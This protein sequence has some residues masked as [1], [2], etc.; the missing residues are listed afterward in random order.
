MTPAYEE[1]ANPFAVRI[2]TQQAKFNLPAYPTTTIGSFPQTKEIRS[3][4]A[5]YK[6]GKL[7]DA[8]YKVKMEEEI[9]LVVRKQEEIGLDGMLLAT[10]LFPVYICDT[11]YYLNRF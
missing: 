4:R 6:S 2:A 8:E 5:G 3:A 1:R 11:L 10:H 7:S 9:Q